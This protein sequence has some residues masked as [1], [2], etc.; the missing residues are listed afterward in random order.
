VR[1]MENI[2]TLPQNVV[3]RKTA[4][5]KS[6]LDSVRARLICEDQKTNLFKSGFQNPRPEDV[7]LVGFTKHYEPFILIGGKYSIDYCKKHVFEIKA[8]NQMKNVFIG[9]EEFKFEPLSP[10]N[11]SRMLRLEGEEHSHYENATYFILDRLMREVNPEEV[12]LAPFENETDNLDNLDADFRKARISFEEEIAFLRS[13]IVKR[14]PDAYMVIKQLFEITDRLT[15]YYPIYEFSF[16]Y[17]KNG[18]VA[19]VLIDGI[20]GK[21]NAANFTKVTEKVEST[22]KIEKKHFSSIKNQFFRE[23]TKKEKLIDSIISKEN[24]DNSSQNKPLEKEMTPTPILKT[25]SKFDL[26]TAITLAIDSLKRLGLT[27]KIQPLKV[28]PDGEFYVVELSLQ[29][30]MAKVWINPKTREIKEYLLIS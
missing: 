29:N 10:E 18:K 28:S 17:A 3:D 4:I 13:K 14:P 21:L 25:E 23:N 26:E 20:T 12:P 2:E 27:S 24:I 1:T 16:Q 22:E 5:L 30:K 7:S 9:G 15:V 11:P 6:R 8:D 19:T